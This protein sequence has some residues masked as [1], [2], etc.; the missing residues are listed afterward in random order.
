MSTSVIWTKP[1]LSRDSSVF[2]TAA[3]PIVEFLIGVG[4]DRVDHSGVTLIFHLL[5]TGRILFGWDSRPALFLAGCLHSVYGTP[6]FHSP[7]GVP[8]RDIDR[9]VGRETERLVDLYSKVTMVSLREE[10]LAV[11]FCVWITIGAEPSFVSWS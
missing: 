4:A 1:D 8:R 9:L 3:T 2:R 6:G 7:L 5:N 11:L 10:L